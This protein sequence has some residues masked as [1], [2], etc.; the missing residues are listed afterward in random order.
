MRLVL[1]VLCLAQLAKGKDEI[2][3]DCQK[4]CRSIPACRNDPHAHGSY[5]K[6][7]QHEAVCFG[8]YYRDSSKR[9]YCFHPND[10][11][12]PQSNPVKCVKRSH[13]H[14]STYRSSSSR[15][16]DPTTTKSTPD[17]PFTTTLD[18]PD[19]TTLD[20]PLTTTLDP[21][22]TTTLDP[23]IPQLWIPR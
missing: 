15:P 12:C 10:P 7:W 19:T 3:K 20:P 8:I 16:I 6:S 2:I 22:D 5:C 1:V 18:P 11:T 23:Q 14:R 4:L 9:K 21:P 13:R 17:P